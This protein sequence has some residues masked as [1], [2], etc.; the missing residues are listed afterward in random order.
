MKH[1]RFFTALAAL[2]FIAFLSFTSV[3][4]VLA[5]EIDW[6]KLEKKA[7]EI[8]KAEGHDISNIVR[9]EDSFI[10]RDDSGRLNDEYWIEFYDT[11]KSEI[12]EYLVCLT[13]EGILVGLDSDNPCGKDRKIINDPDPRFVDEDQLETGKDAIRSFLNKY[14]QACISLVDDMEASQI[15]TQGDAVYYTLV[16]YQTPFIFR[17]RVEP[18]ARI[19]YFA[20]LQ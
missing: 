20:D 10:S 11:L 7:Q 9:V 19:E 18:S 1:T 16:N 17:V 3:S 5:K 2:L 14:N 12:S 15:I 6:E 13:T 8:L 4:P